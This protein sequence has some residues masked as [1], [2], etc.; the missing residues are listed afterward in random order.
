MNSSLFKNDSSFDW[1]YPEHLQLISQKHWTPIRIARKAAKFLALP[2]SKVLDIGSGIGKF[3]LT[4]AFHYPLTS[5]YG[6]EQRHELVHF[7]EE[8]K[9]YVRLQNANFIHANFT[10]VNFESF[11]HFYFYNSFWENIDQN[12]KIDET[13]ETS[14]NLYNYYTQFMFNMLNTR[15]S[16]TRLVT[17]Q[18]EAGEIP[19]NYMLV[20]T[21]ENSLLKMWIKA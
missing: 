6:V 17:F 20:E 18:A 10:Q 13:I 1:L 4:A 21:S 9:N 3:C 12:N 7:A 8:A 14:Y 5:F 15:P 2:S 11:D 16:G 19:A